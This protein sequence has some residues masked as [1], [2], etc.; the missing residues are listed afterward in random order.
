LAED[1]PLLFLLWARLRRVFLRRPAV[2]T[3]I[4]ATEAT[5]DV[6]GRIRGAV[7][8]FIAFKY[9]PD[10]IVGVTVVLLICYDLI[11]FLTTNLLNVEGYPSTV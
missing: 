4:G 1:L 9:E 8:V 7:T 10:D 3:V 5:C 2:C 6:V 11:Y